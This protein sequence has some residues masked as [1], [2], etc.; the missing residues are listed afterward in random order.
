[1]QRNAIE[2]P[3]DWDTHGLTVAIRASRTN[4]VLVNSGHFLTESSGYSV[5][6]DEHPHLPRI[7]ERAAL[8]ADRSL[9][10]GNSSIIDCASG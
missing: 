10:E 9:A 5:T 3:A 2:R 6:A 8:D 1:M 4:P 7:V